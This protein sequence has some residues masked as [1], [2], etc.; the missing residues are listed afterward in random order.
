[1]PAHV[2]QKFKAQRVLMNKVE[3]LETRKNSQLLKDVV[4]STT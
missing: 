2:D 3:R 4:Y 1:M